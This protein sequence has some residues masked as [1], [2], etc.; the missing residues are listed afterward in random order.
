MTRYLTCSARGSAVSNTAC[1]SAS[2]R[3]RR[4]VAVTLAELAGY[5]LGATVPAAGTG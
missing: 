3:N 5:A 2:R 4:L 1:C